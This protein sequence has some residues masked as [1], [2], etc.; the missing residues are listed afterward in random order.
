MLFRSKVRNLVHVRLG[1]DGAFELYRS[2]SLQF[3][4]DLVGVYT[5]VTETVSA[6]RLV[7]QPRG[8]VRVLDTRA[9]FGSVN[10]LSNV[11]RFAAGTT[12]TVDLAPAGVPAGAS[13]VVLNLV[14][15]NANIGNWST[16]RDG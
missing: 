1:T 10:N 9:A 4:V 14:A 5:T 6:G 3:V 12:S 2:N 13:A 16:Y 15:I 8:P 7:L 11:G